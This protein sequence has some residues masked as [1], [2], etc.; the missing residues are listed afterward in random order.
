M[1]LDLI[2]FVIFKLLSREKPASPKFV[3][4]LDGVDSDLEE[5]YDKEQKRKR[6]RKHK[7]EKDEFDEFIEVDTSDISR[8]GPP[9]PLPP[10]TILPGMVPPLVLPPPIPQVQAPSVIPEPVAA[11]TVDPLAF[12]LNAASDGK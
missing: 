1:Y 9:L 8:Q 11:P 5:K 12:K 3:V 10:Q 7:K 2:K 6:R 4:T